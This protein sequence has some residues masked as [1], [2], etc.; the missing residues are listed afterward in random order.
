MTYPAREED[1]GIEGVEIWITDGEK[2]AIP[3]FV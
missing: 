3:C 1:A 2:K